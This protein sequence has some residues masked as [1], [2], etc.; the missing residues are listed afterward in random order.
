ML[1]PQTLPP[2]LD[3]TLDPATGQ[4]VAKPLET[5]RAEAAARLDDLHADY[6]S[7]ATGRPTALEKDTWAIKTEAANA[8][9]G[10]T[11]LS[12]TATAFLASFGL[13]TDAQKLDWAQRA[14]SNADAWAAAVGAAE[15]W[16]SSARAALWAAASTD[17]LKAASLAAEVAASAL[18]P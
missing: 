10:K 2:S 8:I 1:P 16:R 13:T 14:K 15:K 7:R 17:A 4:Y 12:P 11:A 3:V 6:L 18:K 5:L 9:I